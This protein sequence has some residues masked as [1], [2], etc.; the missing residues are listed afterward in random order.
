MFHHVAMFKF[1]EDVSAET[2]AELRA[3][4]IMLPGLVPSIRTYQVARNVGLSD[5]AWDLVV[6]GGFDDEAGWRE[7]ATHPDHTPIVDEIRGLV[8]SLAR[9]Q[10]T[11]LD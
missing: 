6:I 2:I 4:L 5:D 9:L 11:E 8:G 3:R 10:T 7:Y 1:K